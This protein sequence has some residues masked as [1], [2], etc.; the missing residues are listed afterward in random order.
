MT[1]SQIAVSVCQK[2]RALADVAGAKLK[3]TN[4]NAMGYARIV[5]VLF[6]FTTH[7]HKVVVKGSLSDSVLA[8]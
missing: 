2:K 8:H 4:G 6:T 3:H 5:R 1:G 7:F